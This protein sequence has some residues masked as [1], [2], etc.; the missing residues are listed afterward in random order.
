MNRNY[1][2]IILNILSVVALVVII[3]II[4][5]NMK[6]KVIIIEKKNKENF[7]QDNKVPRNFLLQKNRYLQKPLDWQVKYEPGANGTCGDVLWHYMSPRMI[8]T[9]NC[10]K[11]NE[12]NSNYVAPTGIKDELT[13]SYDGTKTQ[14]NLL[15]KYNLL[16]NEIAPADS[17]ASYYNFPH[18]LS[19][20]MNN[21][22]VPV[23]ESYVNKLVEDS[24]KCD[25]SESRNKIYNFH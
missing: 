20:T 14:N 1:A 18:T 25:C 9:D 15:D 21:G 5:N 24:S 7:K 22:I 6:P 12:L 11:R 16:Y 3:W 8:L 19:A 17:N 23:Q 13:A 2:N 10:L 4:M